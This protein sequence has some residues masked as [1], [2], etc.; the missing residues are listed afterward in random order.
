[1]AEDKKSGM[2]E[3]N[4]EFLQKVYAE[5]AKIPS[6][7]V[8][9]YGKLAELAGYQRASREVGIAMSRVPEGSNLPCHRVVNK[10]GTLAPGNIFGGQEKQKAMLAEEGVTFRVD[11]TINMERHMWPGEFVGEQM[12]LFDL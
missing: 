9:T 12:S 8:S 4:E 6:G 5:A 3:I 10:N 1:M 7:K 11:G 2:I